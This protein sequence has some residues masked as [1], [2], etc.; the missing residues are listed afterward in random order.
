[1]WILLF[2][3]TAVEAVKPQVTL[4]WWF[5]LVV[6]GFEPLALV[7]GNVDPGLIHPGVLILRVFSSKVI[8]PH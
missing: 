5:V 2:D 3:K 1:M 6:W 4:S 8:N 7:E